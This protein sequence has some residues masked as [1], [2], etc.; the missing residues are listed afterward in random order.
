MVERVTVGGGRERCGPAIAATRTPWRVGGLAWLA[1]Y[2][3]LPHGTA[4]AQSRPGSTAD[5]GRA[6][7]ASNAP[8]APAPSFGAA[9]PSPP[10][11]PTSPGANPEPLSAVASSAEWDEAINSFR[12][13]DFDAAIG[14]L[15]FLLYPRPRVD[16]QREWRAREYLGAALWWTGRKAEA[17]DEFTALLVR[18]PPARLDPV[19]YPPPMIQDFETLRGNLLRLGVLRPDSK[20]SLPT[21]PPTPWVAPLPL[22]LFPFGV[23]QF[24]NQ[25]PGK[26]IAFLAAEGTLAAGSAWLYLY[27]RDEGLHSRATDLPRAAQV[28]AGAAFW[29]VATWG[30]IDALVVRGDLADAVEQARRELSAPAPQ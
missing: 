5:R 17:L 9:T 11:N 23:G 8:A 26:G 30:V 4:S 12:Y 20:P 25:Q 15:R 21:P 14:K 2:A 10:P 6:G 1:L 18:N 3:L 28:A 7:T 16:R 24:A 19:S 29:A 13:Q 22:C 27:N